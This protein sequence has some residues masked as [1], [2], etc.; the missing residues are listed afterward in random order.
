MPP[1][2]LQHVNVTKVGRAR[3]VIFVPLDITA[4]HVLVRLQRSREDWS[5]G[6]SVGP[7]NCTIWDDGY[8][9]TGR[10]LGTATSASEG[11]PLYTI[12]Y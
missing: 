11:V 7:S 5:D 12:C 3:S 4:L 2:I 10:C 8:T 1:I 6:R 9:G